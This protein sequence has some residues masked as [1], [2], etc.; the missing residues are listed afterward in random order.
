[1]CRNCDVCVYQCPLVCYSHAKRLR[2]VY[3]SRKIKSN[4]SSWKLLRRVISIYLWPGSQRR[5]TKKRFKFTNPIVRI[6]LTIYLW[7]FPLKSS[8]ALVNLILDNFPL[9]WKSILYS[10]VDEQSSSV[11]HDNF[12]L[13]IFHRSIVFLPGFFFSFRIKI[14][15]DFYN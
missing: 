11:T 2:W 15:H 5:F 3:M 10:N 12:L 13:V 7:V 6:Y 1:M 4:V 8:D 9:D 14:I